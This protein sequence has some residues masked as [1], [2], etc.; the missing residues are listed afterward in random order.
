MP[1]KL[2]G[3]LGTPRPEDSKPRRYSSDRQPLDC[4]PRTFRPSVGVA[5]MASTA[6]ERSNEV[7]FDPATVGSSLAYGGISYQ[8]R[9]LVLSAEAENGVLP[10]Y[11]FH[12]GTKF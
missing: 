4:S 12:I 2:A 9:K 3:F 7:N 6:I 8:W 11:G 5:T 1:A 10:S